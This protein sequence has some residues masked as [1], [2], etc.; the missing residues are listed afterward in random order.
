MDE[1]VSEYENDIQDNPGAAAAYA[2]APRELQLIFIVRNGIDKF[3]I[4]F[5]ETNIYVKLLDNNT[6]TT[7]NM[8]LL[9]RLGIDGH[10]EFTYTRKIGRIKLDI[11]KTIKELGLDNNEVVFVDGQRR[12]IRNA[13][14]SKIAEDMAT[15]ESIELVCSTRVGSEDGSLRKIKVLVKP[16]HFCHDMLEEISGLFGRTGLKFKCGRVVLRGGD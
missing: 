16:S 3:N 1:H 5:D 11:S 13:R 15:E 8:R 12:L 4:E 2:R 10:E 7:V 9:S 6:L 14:I